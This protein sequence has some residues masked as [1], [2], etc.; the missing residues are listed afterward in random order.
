[1]LD[2][3]QLDFYDLNGYLSVEDVFSK[4]Q[5]DALSD[6]TDQFVEKSRLVVEEDDIFGLESDHSSENPRLTRIKDPHK[7][8]ALYEDIMRDN[9]LLDILQD[10][11]GI[12]IRLQA[13]KLNMKMPG[14]GRQ[15]E[16]H[17]DWGHYPHT[18][19]DLLAVGVPLDNATEENGCMLVLPGSH[20]WPEISHHQDG[21]FVGAVNGD[22][23][24][25]QKAVP[26]TMNTGA[27]S[28]HHVRT[29]HAS[30]PNLSENPRRLLLLSYGAVDAFPLS[31]L[32]MSWD[33]W[34]KRIVRGRPTFQ[35]RLER[36]P[37]IFPAPLKSESSNI[38]LIQSDLKKSHF[39]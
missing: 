5:I 16:W 34:N 4:T 39:S 9:A 1:M 3:K 22:H 31:G 11:I 6:V 30:A 19:D 23:I 33:D 10:L 15:V 38:F 27:I 13:T 37:V 18:N 7:V 25:M 29:L 8:H 28:I 32:G 20:K 12:D 14:G 36:L 24:D 2:V 35:P 21:Y 17:T 26:M